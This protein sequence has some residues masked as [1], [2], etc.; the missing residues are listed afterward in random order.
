MTVIDLK[1]AKED[2]TVYANADEPCGTENTIN[3]FWHVLTQ[4][5]MKAN[6]HR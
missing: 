3:A 2:K 1:M 5:R 6:L 4:W